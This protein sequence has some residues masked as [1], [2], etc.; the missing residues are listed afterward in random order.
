MTLIGNEEKYKNLGTSLAIQGVTLDDDDFYQC[1]A[2]SDAGTATGIRRVTVNNIHLQGPSRVWV[3]CDDKQQPTQNAYVP[4]RGD[5]PTDID[6]AAIEYLPWEQRHLY[7]GKNGSNVV[8][9][10]CFPTNRDPRSGLTVS[11]PY[12]IPKLTEVPARVLKVIKGQPL[13]LKCSAIGS[14][15]PDIIWREGNNI[16]GHSYRG[17]LE[18]SPE[19]L[20]ASTYTCRAQNDAGKDEASS[21]VEF[22]EKNIRRK[23][24]KENISVPVT[25]LNCPHEQSDV[26]WHYDMERIEPNVENKDMHI[27]P[28]GSLVLHYFAESDDLTKFV[29]EVYENGK[30]KTMSPKPP[31]K[32]ELG[33]IAPVVEVPQP[34][35]VHG[36]ITKSVRFDCI[37]KK[38]TPLLTKI[39]WTKDN[40]NI[41]V[42]GRKMNLMVR[43]KLKMYKK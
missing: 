28:N 43:D 31:V 41:E 36:K 35:R 11:P 1:I 6:P 13:T 14:P 12:A 42:D 38:G 2:R 22:V 30:G 4:P 39:R 5:V 26:T 15:Q 20:K 18:I 3:E 21:K 32:M 9:F 23:P 27:L 24:K 37:L 34:N 40:V 33:E 25:V 7:E 29:C 16:L 17:I 8:Y 10:K 19:N